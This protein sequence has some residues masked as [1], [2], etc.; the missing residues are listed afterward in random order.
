MKYSYAIA[1]HEE[2]DMLH[3]DAHMFAQEEFYQAGPDVM[4]SIM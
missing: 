3:P 1:Q 4:A 2:A